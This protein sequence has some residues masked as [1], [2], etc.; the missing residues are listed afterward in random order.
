LIGT[1]T[2]ADK[3][4]LN[5]PVVDRT[6]TDLAAAMTDP[7][8]GVV[9]A[10]NCSKLV[11]EGDLR[12]LGREL[13]S[14]A[15][16]AE[17]LLLVYYTGHGLLS[18]KRK[19]LYLALPDSESAAPEFNSLEYGKV[20]DA[21]LDSPAQTKVIILDCCFSGRSITGA[22]AESATEVI[23][24][25]EVDGT[26]ILTSAPQHGVA[27]FLPGED[28]TAFTGRLLHLLN[29]GIPKGPE[30]LTIDDM[31]RALRVI[32]K[33]EGLP[34]P[35]KSSTRTAHMLALTRNGSRA[36]F[37]RAL[38]RSLREG[39]A[40][41]EQMLSF[42]HE[43]E[44]GAVRRW[45]HASD[46]TSEL[47]ERALLLAL[48]PLDGLAA[49]VVVKHLGAIAD[50]L[51]L[52]IDH[53]LDHGEITLAAW[54]LDAIS[55][56]PGD[57]E[58]LLLAELIGPTRKE[59][60]DWQGYMSAQIKLLQ[61]RVRPV[62]NTFPYTCAALQVGNLDSWE[63]FL[64]R[65][66]LYNEMA[67]DPSYQRVV[68]W[69]DWLCRTDFAVQSKRPDWMQ[70]LS[71]VVA[72]HAREKP[73]DSGQVMMLDE[74]W[75]VMILKLAMALGCLPQVLEYMAASLKNLAM[76]ITPLSADS[77][78]SSTNG[79]LLR[80]LN[81]GLWQQN[82]PAPLVAVMDVVRILLGGSPRDL[83]VKAMPVILDDY[84]NALT[85]ALKDVPVKALR[86]RLQCAILD[87]SIS[88]KNLVVGIWLLNR[89]ATDH[90]M[91]SCLLDYLA[92]LPEA[93]FPFS[94]QLSSSF[95]A[96]LSLDQRLLGY[97]AARQLMGATREA[98]LNPAV[99]LRTVG[100]SGLSNTELA[101]ACYSA[102][103]AGLSVEGIICAMGSVIQSFAD[104]DERLI[105][106]P[107][108]DNVLREFQTL[109]SFGSGDELPGVNEHGFKRISEQELH[110]CW[111]RI[112]SGAFGRK[113]GS[114][115]ATYLDG[116]L[117]DEIQSKRS[118]LQIIASKNRQRQHRR[119]PLFQL[120]AK[121]TTDQR[122][123]P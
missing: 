102:R 106:L 11:N 121:R 42:F 59:S 91:A 68:D 26:Y 18:G 79:N 92:E 31:Y 109:S 70:A 7:D 97:R 120:M 44:T 23:G 113:F 34:E 85:E 74:A 86:N 13:R 67:V 17:D 76:S 32:M 118:M 43:R 40:D 82:V 117:R 78:A 65:K 90:E 29:E 64:V 55:K 5:V 10:S 116:Q 71:C 30:L 37:D 72:M 103:Q 101:L 110:E 20:R 77:S 84:G 108:L 6:I 62:R 48:S 99:L 12:E 56:L 52:F 28:H 88:N 87:L 27:L 100:E 4:L 19:E 54:C 83:P 122:Q 115:F 89:W 8:Y 16:R 22:M 104:R 35:Q 53:E 24:Q 96:T 14:A 38:K 51:L 3:D 1:S 75:A 49:N 112:M 107:A 36:T 61:S 73:P 119:R 41:R 45:L 94:E 9:P 57:V 47:R 25:I 58:D 95:W 50:D 123:E 60:S 114:A 46:M 81:I 111:D 69:T 39:S 105:Q 93:S 66:L 2:Y 98:V 15:S 63:A 80:V 21:V 33:A